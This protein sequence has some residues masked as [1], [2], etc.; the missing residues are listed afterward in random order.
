MDGVQVS[1]CTTELTGPTITLGLATPL[2]LGNA[3]KLH[4]LHK[5][6]I[7][8]KLFLKYN[9][10][11]PSSA[12]VERLFSLGNLVLAPKRNRLT[13]ARFEKLL[14]YIQYLDHG[15]DWTGLDWTP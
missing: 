15:L 12:P 7:I 8:K 13:D 3:K 4:C 5:Y 14:G 1:N 2:Y 9:T 10:T 6:P 11:I